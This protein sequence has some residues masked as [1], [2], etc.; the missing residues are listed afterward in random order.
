VHIYI[1]FLCTG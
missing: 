1:H